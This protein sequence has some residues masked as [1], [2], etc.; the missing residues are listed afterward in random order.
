MRAASGKDVSEGHQATDSIARLEAAAIAM[1]VVFF[2]VRAV[3]TAWSTSA[4]FDEPQYIFSGYAYFVEGRFDRNIEHPPLAKELV[5][6]PML[7]LRPR[8][9]PDAEAMR[10]HHNYPEQIPEPEA[11]LGHQF[12]FIHNRERAQV[13]ILAAR[14]GS[15]AVMAAGACV[16]WRWARLLYGPAGGLMS[17]VVFTFDP[18]ILAHAA[19]A[20]GDAIF[21]VIMLGAC[22]AWWRFLKRRSWLR[23]VV[24]GAMLGVA[25][26][27]RVIGVL[28]LP[29]WALMLAVQ[30][31]AAERHALGE[32]RARWVHSALQM[33][34]AAVVAL[35]VLYVSYGFESGR[36]DERLKWPFV[37]VLYGGG[38]PLGDWA[39]R[40]VPMPNLVLGVFFQRAHLA[41][42][43]GAFLMG[44][45]SA[46]GWWYYFPVAFF[47][48]TPLAL[49][50][51]LVLA[52]EGSIVAALRGR[53]V[54]GDLA[55]LLAAILYGVFCMASGPNIGYR[56]LL[57]ALVLA[58]VYGGRVMVDAWRWRWAQ[59]ALV[60]VLC[61]WLGASSL[62]IHPHYLAYFNEI[63]GGPKNGHRYLVDSNLD[64]GQ[65]LPALKEWMD[66]HG[67]EE[68]NLSYFGTA[69]PAYYGVKYQYL[70]GFDYLRPE[71]VWDPDVRPPAEYYAIS[72]TNL[73]GVYFSRPETYAAFRALEPVGH[74]GH[75]ILIYRA[76]HVDGG[77]R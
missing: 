16:A 12:L 5:A 64:W 9:S 13:L 31:F 19:N 67:V 44:Q 34:F 71:R 65:A 69:D 22:F 58:T 53:C 30:R 68:V 49:Q 32:E 27:A 42:G 61:L 62:W 76:S 1:L 51:L 2:V 39:R 38:N 60:A 72:A 57:P 10:S 3:H 21:A 74:A 14:L 59:R 20:S 43:H 8:F 36:P 75:A 40:W 73:W 25:V 66:K 17:A 55:V 37:Q 4:T 18:N 46:R 35:A 45:V 47:L 54:R 26:S 33:F 63:V 11:P 52:A 29:M 48:K 24:A 41:T 6:L 23:L 70:P 15:I 56:F 28:L 50:M 77:E 7:V